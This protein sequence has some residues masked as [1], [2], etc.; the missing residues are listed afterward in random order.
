MNKHQSSYRQIMKATSL[1][2][3]VQVF[4]IIISIVRSKFVAVLLGPAGMGIVGLL[5]S[6]TGL[7]AGLSNFGLGTSAVKNIAE[8]DATGDENR[9]SIVISV[10]RRLVWI[11]GILGV[12]ITLIFSSW[13]S[14]F[15]FG[16][17]DYT[18]AFVWISITLLFNQLSTGQLVL[19]QG[20]RRLQD[21]AKANVY[22]SIVGLF[23]TVPLYYKFGFQGIV[24]VIIIT[25]S[26]TLFFVWY[27]AKKT[28]IK[29][30]KINTE[31]TVIEGKSMMI[32]GFMIS[33]SGLISIL[34]AYLLR[35]FISRTGNVA[36][37]G[38]YNAG[39]TI[40]NTYVGM[41]FTAMATDYFPRLSAVAHSNDLCKQ[42]INQQAEI[43]ILILAPILMIFLIFINWAVILLYSAKFLA[44]TGMIYWAALGML[45][46]AASWAVGFVL[47]AK[48]ASKI[49]FW[50]ELISN[51]YILGF[52][53]LGYH[54][55]NLS[56]LGLAFLFSYF[57]ALIQAF[58][59]AK[60][61]YKFS[62]TM[63]FVKI[64]VIQFSL[65]LTSFAIVNLVNKPYTY[66]LG[67]ILIGVS[68]WYSY[69]ELENR[70]GLNEIIKDSINK[71]KKR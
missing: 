46:K 42:N 16:N 64:F 57:I 13:L 19:L 31:I 45:F 55:G 37:V 32:M 24:P 40:I 25:A 27:F 9:I 33:L 61:K 54:Y 50:S 69:V 66:L 15:T 36:D 56:G 43:A 29:K 26:I 10:M 67:I 1:F 58:V 14:Q 59:I 44:V 8:A 62:F 71:I 22:G 7:V 41:I 12:A 3:G 49:F 35:I 20:L 63:S 23:I 6:T 18:I 2:G 38:L 48:G 53:I 70:I 11:T 4:Q 30:V 21:L 60:V 5:T 17:K 65:A 47:L 52:S 34:V 39:F 51:I 28:K 68:G